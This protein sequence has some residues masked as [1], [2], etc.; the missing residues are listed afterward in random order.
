[1]VDL[2]FQGIKVRAGSWPISD[3]VSGGDHMSG[4]TVTYI[5]HYSVPHLMSVKFCVID[6]LPFSDK[7]EEPCGVQCR[8]EKAST[9]DPKRL[10][11]KASVKAA[12]GRA[13][14]LILCTR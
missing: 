13:D 12:G 2:N 3:P 11:S 5:V 9:V 7:P 4:R 10:W 6:L 14:G 8:R 1:V